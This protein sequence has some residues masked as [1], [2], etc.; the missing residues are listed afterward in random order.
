MDLDFHLL[1]CSGLLERNESSKAQ[2][3]AKNN[4][5]ERKNKCEKLLIKF[6]TVSYIVISN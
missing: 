3:R 2:K 6:K 5:K 4:M 1:K